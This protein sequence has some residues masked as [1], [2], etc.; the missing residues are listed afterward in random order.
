MIFFILLSYE[1]FSIWHK[2]PKGTWAFIEATPRGDVSHGYESFSAVHLKQDQIL[3]LCDIAAMSTGHSW[4]FLAFFMMNF[5]VGALLI[6]A[7]L[8]SSPH[9]RRAN[10]WLAL[11][12][13]VL[14]L[15][16]LELTLRVTGLILLYPQ[17]YRAS[18]P[19]LYLPGPLLYFY[20]KDLSRSQNHWTQFRFL[21]FLPAILAGV[22]LVYSG[23]ED[24]PVATAD[25]IRPPQGRYWIDVLTPIIFLFAY[26]TLSYIEVGKFRTILSGRF[27]NLDAI[28][29]GWLNHIL[30]LVA[31]A[32]SIVC[33]REIL[34]FNSIRFYPLPAGISIFILGTGYFALTRSPVT[35]WD[36]EIDPATR[37]FLP[38]HISPSES[39]FWSEEII[40]VMNEKRPYLNPNFTIA[41]LSEIMA[42]PT[43]YLGHLINQIFHQSFAEF[44]N[45]YRIG[46]ILSHADAKQLRPGDLEVAARQLGFPS[47]SAFKSCFKS[48]TGKSLSQYCASSTSPDLSLSRLT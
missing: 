19:L 4:S 2:Q 3:R 37:K 12:L 44:V 45:S 8:R 20:V 24:L 5:S 33:L 46:E 43:Y 11:L 34:A 27:S 22:F 29:L 28:K 18:L 41:D 25:L 7:L 16:N 40:R 32:W 15:L 31:A 39:S 26:L 36:D 48:F 38:D 21:H 30:Q 10:H 6:A 14:L 47:R 17:F 42:I 35:F 1:L 9:R 13:L 23:P